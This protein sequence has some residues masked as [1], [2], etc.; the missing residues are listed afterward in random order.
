MRC[1]ILSASSTWQPSSR[2][3]AATVVLPVAIPPVRPTRSIRVW[4]PRRWVHAR[5]SAPAP[6]A[7]CL[8]RVAHQHGDGQR[9]HAARHRRDR[10]GDFRDARMNVAHQH[11]AFLAELRQLRRKIRKDALRLGCIGDAIDAHIDHRRA[12][13]HP[14][15]LDHGRAADRRDH[16]VGAAHDVGQVAR[17][18]VADRHRRVG[19]HQQQRHR[20]S[21]NVAAPHDDGVRLPRAECRCAAEFPCTP[22]ACRPQVPARP[23]T[24]R[25]RF[26]G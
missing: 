21:H 16:D 5:L 1:A 10:S 24:R 3:I 20:L 9:P 22:R 13:T 19:M 6:Q 2:S 12:G 7:G 14:T 17:L 4:P 11:G 23:E 15:G 25:P 8:H 26:T 18:R